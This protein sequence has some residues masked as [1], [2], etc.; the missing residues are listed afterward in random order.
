M[1]KRLTENDIQVCPDFIGR[2]NILTLKV[3]VDLKRSTPAFIPQFVDEDPLVPYHAFGFKFSSSVRIFIPDNTMELNAGEI[4]DAKVSGYRASKKET[5]DSRHYVY[6]NVEVLR[7]KELKVRCIDWMD[8][9]LYETTKSG[10]RTVKTEKRLL[11]K[12]ESWFRRNG[13]A[14]FASVC[15]LDGAIIG[16][17]EWEY[18]SE[19]DYVNHL[20]TAMGKK[21]G[22]P[23][24]AQAVFRKLPSPPILVSL[25]SIL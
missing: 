1:K 22:K 4:W 8:G 13:G 25:D 24:I 18:R 3:G 15:S 7:R 2:G 23:E 5:R 17:R 6:I 9:I 20:I 10:S 16:V 12:K 19:R 14:I 21:I 11:E